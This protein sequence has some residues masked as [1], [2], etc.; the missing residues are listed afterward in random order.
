MRRC[1]RRLQRSKHLRGTRDFTKQLLIARRRVSH[2][3]T[4]VRIGR[5]YPEHR[6]ACARACVSFEERAIPIELRSA[7]VT[8]DSHSKLTKQ[9]RKSTRLNSSHV[10][11]SY[12]VFCLKKKN[13]QCHST[14]I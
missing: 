7:V 13:D 4:S 14:V 1:F 2:A 5:E 11:I 9:D 6:A 8:F 10:E 3:I 12:A